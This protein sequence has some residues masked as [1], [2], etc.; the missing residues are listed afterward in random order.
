MT[1]QRYFDA[2][3]SVGG[4]HNLEIDHELRAIDFRGEA[5]TFRETTSAVLTSLNHCLEIIVQKE[6]GLKK[7]LD[8]ET[9]KRKKVEDELE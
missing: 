7:K 2:C 6:D 4:A 5:I 1:L 3:I 8:R 9:D